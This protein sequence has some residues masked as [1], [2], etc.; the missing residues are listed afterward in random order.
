MVVKI[1]EVKWYSQIM[2]IGHYAASVIGHYHPSN[3]VIV[4]LDSYWE[5]LIQPHLA[6][7]I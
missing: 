5:S 2:I 3:I 4:L 6:I 7:L 1:V